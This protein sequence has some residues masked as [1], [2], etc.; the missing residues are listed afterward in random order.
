MRV[1]DLLAELADCDPEAVVIPANGSFSHYIPP[2][3]IIRRSKALESIKPNPMN[4]YRP[5]VP[6]TTTRYLEM[7]ETGKI[8]IVILG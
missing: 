4:G 5:N 7:P 3:S 6:L 8:N 2:F 1:K